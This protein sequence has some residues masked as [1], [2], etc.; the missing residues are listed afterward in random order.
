MRSLALA[1]VIGLL[2]A[3]FIHI[4]IVLALPGWTGM[5]AWTR[6]EA[7][8]APNRFYPLPNEASNTGLYN[9][10]PYIRT[11]VCRFD[12]TDGPLRVVASGDVA[13]WTLSAYDAAADE[14]YSMNDRSAIGAGVDVAFVTPAQMLQ[15]RRFMPQ[16]L[17]RSVLVEL[18]EPE[19]YV[20]L[21]AV[22]PM[23]SQE[24]AVR[25]FLA[26]AACLPL[27]VDAG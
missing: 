23:P 15:L 11:A 1:S 14:T 21:R 9:T 10:D 27:K 7:L 12:I 5:D 25:A 3:A 24:P 6:V 20:A 13:I 8:G 18:R 17:E 26:N 16:A 22:A 19:G 4:I 2:G